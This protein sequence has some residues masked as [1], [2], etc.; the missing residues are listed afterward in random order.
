MIRLWWLLVL[1][2]LSSAPFLRAWDYGL[3]SLDD[4]F[5]ILKLP[6]LIDWAGWESV[7]VAFTHVKDGIWMPLTRLSYALDHAV[8]GGWYGGFH[9]H[10]ILVHSANACLVWWLLRTILRQVYSDVRRIDWVCL[11]AALFWAIHPLRC[12][13]VV[14]LASRKDVLSFFWEMLAFVFWMRGTSRR[15]TALAMAFFV[16]GSFCKPSVMTFPVLCLLLDAFV[17]REVRVWRLVLPVAYMVGL[18]FFAAWQQQSGGATQDMYAQTLLQRILGAAAA[19]GIYVRNTVWPDALAVQCIKRW[20]DAPRFLLPG[21]VV[22]GAWGLFLV[23]KLRAFWDARAGIVCRDRETTGW[24]YELPTPPDLVFVGAAWFAVAVAPMLGI[25]NFG[26]HAFADRFTYIPAFGIS[27]LVAVALYKASKWLMAVGVVVLAALGVMTWR[28]T[29]YWR[30]DETLFTHTLEVDGDRN[31]LAHS[32]LAN[33]YFEFPHDL[34]SALREFEAVARHDVRYLLPLYDIYVMTLCESGREGEVAERLRHF[35]DLLVK[36]Y[37]SEVI[38]NMYAGDPGTPKELKELYVID[39]AARLAWC[40]ND[41]DGCATAKDMLDRIYTPALDNK[42]IWL[43]LMMKY[44]RL[45]GEDE[46][47]DKCRA[48]LLDPKGKHGYTQFR[49]LRKENAAPSKPI[50]I[51]CDKDKQ[52]PVV[53]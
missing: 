20:P 47:A 48:R 13:S 43:Y 39:Q 38:A 15:D 25:A 19:F 32:V 28:Q 26:Y 31:A 36:S 45:A 33:W 5:Y 37:G 42:P 29:G 14:F 22:S 23:R 30:D 35:Q 49:Y 4:Y 2:A 27:I 24:R 34:P 40:L 18:G 3:V 11:F 51:T 16:L 9:L 10:S 53:K 41:K 7:R 44:H 8:F 52:K 50:K 46:A 12:E 1:V 6:E 17:R 21:L